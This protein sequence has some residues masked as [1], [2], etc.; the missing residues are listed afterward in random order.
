M[1]DAAVSE[2]YSVVGLRPAPTLPPVL[3]GELKTRSSVHHAG[4]LVTSFLVQ[5]AD[6]A[7]DNSRVVITNHL[8]SESGEKRGGGGNY[9]TLADRLNRKR[10]LKG[11]VPHSSAK[12]ELQSCLESCYANPRDS[13][14]KM[15]CIL[16]KYINILY[17]IFIG[18]SFCQMQ[19]LIPFVFLLWWAIWGE[20]QESWVLFAHVT[21]MV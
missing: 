13:D 18:S 8:F 3:Q 16:W 6:G 4:S 7:V 9:H 20:K 12:S 15:W 14:T 1:S 2:H 17:I 11:C 10:T 19:L 21:I 5:S